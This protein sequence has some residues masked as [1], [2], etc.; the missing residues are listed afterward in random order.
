MEAGAQSDPWFWIAF[1]GPI[2]W[3][4]GIFAFGALRRSQAGEPLIPRRPERADF[5][6]SMAS[7][8]NLDNI[9]FRVGGAS[10]C[11]IVSVDQGRLK[12]DLIFPFNL[13]FVFNFYGIS[14]DVRTAEIRSIERRNRLLM[15][16]VVVVRWDG[17]KAYEFR[18]KDPSGFIQAIDPQGRIRARS[19]APS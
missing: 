7:G 8:R 3:I 9:L 11:L 2:L 4:G 15:G 13:F 12:T 18:L 19:T 17:D 5:Y 6:E 14:I 16:E 10:R 1:A